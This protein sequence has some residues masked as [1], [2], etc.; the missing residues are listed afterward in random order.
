[1]TAG[2]LGV[3][4]SGNAGAVGA[5]T[6]GWFTGPFLPPGPRCAPVSLKWSCL[7]DGW[8]RGWSGPARQTTLALLTAGGPLF[9]DFDDGTTVVLREPG[10][11]VLWPPGIAHNV[12]ADA[13]TTVL[14]IRW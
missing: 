8:K 5:A 4:E 10:D 11:Y 1:M 14:T 9:F 6:R 3:V 2:R 7:E 12:T 13:D